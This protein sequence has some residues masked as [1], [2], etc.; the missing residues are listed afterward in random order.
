MYREESRHPSP[1]REGPKETSKALAV[2]GKIPIRF[3]DVDL[4]QSLKIAHELALY[5]YDAYLIRCAQ[6]YRAPLVSLDQNLVAS[7]KKI[8]VQVKEID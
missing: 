8:G 6:K 7:A 1:P 2:Y 3:L 4:E 5:A